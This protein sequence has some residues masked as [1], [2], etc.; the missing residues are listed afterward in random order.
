MHGLAIY[1]W[2]CT[3][4]AEQS[5]RVDVMFGRGWSYLV[6]L[7]F[8]LIGCGGTVQTGVKAGPA[9]PNLNLSGGWYSAEFGDLKV[10]HDGQRVTGTYQDP[11]GPDHNGHF[12]GTILG[13]LL[14]LEWIK[15]GNARAAILPQRGRA[16]LRISRDGK[17]LSGRWGYE[18]SDDDGGLWNA[19]KSQYD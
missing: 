2:R 6:V 17:K 3:L 18:Q 7:C 13:D 1:A 9:V 8:L 15:P 14:R 5:E 4:W 10:V 12:R 11:R 19:E 16:W